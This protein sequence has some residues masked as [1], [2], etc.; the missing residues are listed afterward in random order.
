MEHFFRLK[1]HFRYFSCASLL[2]HA[3]KRVPSSLLKTLGLLYS[4]G[5]HLPASKAPPAPYQQKKNE[6]KKPETTQKKQLQQPKYEYRPSVEWRNN[7][8][9]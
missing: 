4:T 6:E 2:T 3:A 8:S 7:S 5:N 1:T 9:N